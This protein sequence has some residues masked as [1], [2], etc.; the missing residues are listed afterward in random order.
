MVQLGRGDVVGRL[1]PGRDRS[2][3]ALAV[4]AEAVRQCLEEGDARPGGELGEAQ[5]NVAGER[6]V[7]RFAEGPG[8]PC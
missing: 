4:G 1:L 2:G 7:G 6:G 8:T 5:Q 3:D